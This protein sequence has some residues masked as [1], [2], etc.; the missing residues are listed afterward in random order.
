MVKILDSPT[1]ESETEEL[2]A[3]LY[4]NTLQK[5][6][7]RKDF[8]QIGKEFEREKRETQRETANILQ[9]PN[10]LEKTKKALAH[11]I[12]GRIQNLFPDDCMLCKRL[13]NKSTKTHHP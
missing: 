12:V 2:I 3:E 11:Q 13:Q 8:N 4:L 1:K 7:Y 10:Y 6:Q 9:I 5:Y